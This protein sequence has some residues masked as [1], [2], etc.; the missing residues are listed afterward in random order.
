MQWDAEM[1]RS[2][3]FQANACFRR[4]GA[5]GGRKSS[6]LWWVFWKAGARGGQVVV[7]CRG[8]FEV[9]EQDNKQGWGGDGYDEMSRG[10]ARSDWVSQRG[11]LQSAILSHTGT[12]LSGVI[13]AQGCRCLYGCMSRVLIIF[14]CTCLES[15]EGQDT[16]SLHCIVVCVH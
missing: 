12:A 6:G 9:T 8:R 3:V 10:L 1:N 11:N 15:V 13:E 7:Q 14:H 2:V 4:D 5:T 16:D